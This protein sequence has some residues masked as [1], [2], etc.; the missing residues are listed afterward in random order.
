MQISTIVFDILK[1]VIISSINTGSKNVDLLFMIIGLLT[2]QLISTYINSILAFGWFFSKCGFN[3]SA[4]LES[5]N[6]PS[7]D[8]SEKKPNDLSSIMNEVMGAM[9][10]TPKPKPAEVKPLE[11]QGLVILKPD[12]QR[13]G[14]LFSSSENFAGMSIRGKI[15][16]SDNFNNFYSKHKYSM[17]SIIDNFKNRSRLRGSPADN[18]GFLLSGPPGTGKTSFIS[19]LANYLNR[20][21]VLINFRRDTKVDVD[22]F[23]KILSTDVEKYI[24]VFEEFDFATNVI[25]RTECSNMQEIY[26]SRQTLLNNIAACTSDSQKKTLIQEYKKINED[27]GIDLDTLLTT[28][29]GIVKVS[30]RV[31]VA[32]TNQPDKIDIALKQPGRF[33]HTF[34]L[35]YFDEAEIKE[36]ILNYRPIGIDNED[37]KLL[38][39]TSLPS[40][41]WSP[42]E[43]IQMLEYKSSLKEIID[44]IVNVQPIR[45]FAPPATKTE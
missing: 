5:M 19:A 37:I 25:Q 11:Y 8:K 40:G 45:S 34:V 33:G 39:E 38:N 27:I 26:A 3:V 41:V 4:A 16:E 31:I 22:A 14:G 36:L 28:L 17:L 12:F 30:Q 9:F 10:G 42:A 18:L 1:V 15:Y 32:T 6:P 20:S 13:S 35:D 2:I 43:I 29:C 7:S 23:E 24:F 44:T 21:I